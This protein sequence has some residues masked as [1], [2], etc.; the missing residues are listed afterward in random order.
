MFQTIRTHVLTALITA[1]LMTVLFAGTNSRT[2]SVL[3]TAS[4]QAT[5]TKPNLITHMRQDATDLINT[6]ANYRAHRA[7]YDALSYSW[8]DNDFSG[9]NAG[10][11][12]AQFTTAVSNM[13]TIFDAVKS[14]GTLSAGLPTTLHRISN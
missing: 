8:A 12:A 6:E 2:P 5:T 4:A 7:Q 11:T 9:N 10:P 1:A 14:G 13:G 3:P